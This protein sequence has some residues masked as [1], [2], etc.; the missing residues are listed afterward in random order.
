MEG[1]LMI[2]EFRDFLMRGNLLELAV[3][4]SVFQLVLLVGSLNGLVTCSPELGPA[5]VR[6]CA[7][8]RRIDHAVAR[9]HE[10]HSSLSDDHGHD[11]GDRH[12]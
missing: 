2:K 9:P 11:D 10:R 3:P 8:R 6:C 5:E 4:F 12:A 1:K 7:H